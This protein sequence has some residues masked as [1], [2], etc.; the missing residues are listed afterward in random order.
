MMNL[1]KDIKN[2]LITVGAGFI[3]S[4]L[5]RKILIETDCTIHNIDKCGYAS[6]LKSIELIESSFQR[7]NLIK[8]D[9]KDYEA[10]KS[11]ILDIKPDL[12]FHL[13]AESHVD[14]SISNSLPFI[15]SNIIG[16]Y[17]LLESIREYWI[18][19]SESRRNIFRL[20]HISTDEVY[21]SLGTTGEFNEQSRYD[22]KS[23]YSASK[24]SSDHLCK[25]WFNT[26]NLPVIVT[27]CGNNFGPWQYPEKLIPLAILN[28]LQNKNIPIY[29]DGLNIRDWIFVDDHV[30]AL[31]KISNGGTIGHSYCIGSNNE[32]T[33]LDLIYTICQILDELK[34]SSSSYSNLICHVKVRPG[35]DKRY[36]LD[37]RK[38][39]T[40]LN[41]IAPTDFD[42]ALRITVD[43]Y[44]KNF[45]SCI[46]KCI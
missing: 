44:I 24:A 27:N 26:Y 2:I 3:G 20:I 14:N 5:V 30:N 38:I 18:K 34:P 7:H 46:S 16:T 28:A 17:N 13:A 45:D 12:V 32:R 6:S 15:E 39:K 35:H 1:F 9:L 10:T 43:W 19:L 41:W 21:G 29:G 8:I 40:E 33:N 31:I 4:T 42:M 11:A 37:T 36:A 25:A 22:P 23:P